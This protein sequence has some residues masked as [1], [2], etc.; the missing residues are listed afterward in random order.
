MV[1]CTHKYAASARRRGGHAPD[2]MVECTLLQV[3]SEAALAD[4]PPI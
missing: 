4:T 1:E 3:K 2:L